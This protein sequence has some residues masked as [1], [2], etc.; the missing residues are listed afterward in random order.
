MLPQNPL[1]KLEM[2]NTNIGSKS[3]F[4]LFRKINMAVMRSRDIEPTFVAVKSNILKL[5]VTKV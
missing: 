4:P 3:Q 5:C 2:T 1:M